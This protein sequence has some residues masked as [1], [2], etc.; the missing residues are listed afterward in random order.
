ME[1]TGETRAFSLVLAMSETK[2]ELG[3]VSDA[4]VVAVQLLAVPEI[5]VFNQPAG[6]AGAVT[7]S[8]FCA[9]DWTSETP[10]SGNVK[11][12]VPR[13]LVPSCNCTV[14]VMFEPHGPAA[15]KV[16]GWLFVPRAATAP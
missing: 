15:V 6:S 13:L 9:K 3:V 10:P 16:N 1:I 14:A 8:K 12:T 4:A 2:T 7:P 5:F 11:L